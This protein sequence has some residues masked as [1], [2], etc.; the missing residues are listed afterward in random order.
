MSTQTSRPEREVLAA[1]LVRNRLKRSEQREA[2]LDAFLKAGHHV[3][4]ERLLALVRKRHPEI[5]RTTIYRTLRLF[6]RAGLAG[7]LQLD[8]EARFEP[9]WNRCHHDH[10]VCRSC[11][12]ISEFSSPE[13]ERIQ[14]QVAARIG[15]TIEAHRHDVLGL[16]RKCGGKAPRG[17]R[18]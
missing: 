12:A 7:Q 15:F 4:V 10:F 17:S 13:I 11:G 14:R 1:F 16:C 5:G 3:S 6:E 8:D 9:M 18:R 2:I